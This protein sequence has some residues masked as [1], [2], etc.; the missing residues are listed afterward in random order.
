[1]GLYSFLEMSHCLSTPYLQE[2]SVRIVKES[3]EHLENEISQKAK[4]IA[5]SQ[6]AKRLELNGRLKAIVCEHM[7]DIAQKVCRVM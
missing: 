1:M 3:R 7:E 2:L 4:I 6:E 5:Q